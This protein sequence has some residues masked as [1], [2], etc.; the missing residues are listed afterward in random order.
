MLHQ[1]GLSLKMTHARSL[2]L[3]CNLGNYLNNI[4][5]LVIFYSYI[6]EVIGVP[7]P[8]NVLCLSLERDTFS[9]LHCAGS[10]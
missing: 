1:A 4:I 7:L 9:Y 8:K 6:V 10:T 5:T 3:P 2:A